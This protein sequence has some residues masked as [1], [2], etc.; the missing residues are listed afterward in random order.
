MHM[1]T[2]IL[3]QK[4]HRIKLQAFLIPYN[5]ALIS[6]R[7]LEHIHRIL[8]SKLYMLGACIPG[9]ASQDAIFSAGKKKKTFSLSLKL[10]CRGWNS[11]RILHLGHAP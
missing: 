7:I 8:Q 3:S 4:K 9:H 6:M 2:E 11:Q 5:I 10:K 1:H